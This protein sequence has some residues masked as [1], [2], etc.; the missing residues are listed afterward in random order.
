MKIGVSTM[1]KYNIHNNVVICVVTPVRDEI[2]SSLFDMEYGAERAGISTTKRLTLIPKEFK[3]VARL[4]AGDEVD[5]A[6]AK[7]I[8]RKKAMRK[9]YR[10]Y[11]NQMKLA[12]EYFGMAWG[13]YLDAA[14]ELADKANEIDN[15]IVKLTSKES[16][17]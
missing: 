2:L 17:G 10:V 8:A 16:Q 11:H 6:L 1:I 7:E 15:E 12:T 13:R 4:K 14:I 9:M 5:L 3:G